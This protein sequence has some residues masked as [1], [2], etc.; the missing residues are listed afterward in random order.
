M[1]QPRA[2]HLVAL[3]HVLQYVYGTLNQGILLNGTSKLTLQAY[4][5]A[6]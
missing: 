4:S 1:Q 2:P 3:K 6:D 5:D